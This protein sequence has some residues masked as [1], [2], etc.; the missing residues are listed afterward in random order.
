MLSRVAET[1]YWFARYVERAENTAR[2][3]QVNMQLLMDTPRG[4]SPG[5]EC[6]VGIVGQHESFDAL[7]K[8][9]NERNVVRYLIGS[10]ENPGSILNSLTMAR[11][12]GRTVR[13]IMPRSVWESINELYLYAKEEVQQGINK[14]SRDEYLRHIIGGSQHLMGL[15]GGEMY[16]DEAYHFLC[17]GRDLERADMTTRIIDVRSTDLFD[18]NQIES[19][20]LDTLQWISV[21]KSLSSYQSYRRHAQ[22][23]VRRGDVLNFLLK[24][25]YTPRSV[26]HCLISIEASMKDLGNHSPTLLQLRKVMQTALSTD[27]EQISQSALHQMIDHLQL[28]IMQTHDALASGYFLLQYETTQAQSVP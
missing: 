18:E 9:A 26:N 1:I 3:L 25:P 5:W 23:R 21:L 7:Y 14:R 20:T 10:A 2:L 12:N 15:V 13:E 17:V 6:L 19:R 4:V 27:T 28:G 8:E 16:R 24:D 22:I 11:E